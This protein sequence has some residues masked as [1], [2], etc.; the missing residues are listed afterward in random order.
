MKNVVS[1]IQVSYS[2]TLS[3]KI[4]VTSSR[5]ALD[6]LL[7]SWNQNTIELQEEFKILMLN[8][9]NEVLGIY[10]LSKGGVSGTVV[11]IKLLF[12]VALKCNASGLILCHN[13]PSGNTQP[14]SQDKDI[15]CKILK[16]AA[17]MELSI[18]DHMIITRHGHYSFAE[19]GLLR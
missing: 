12:A 7:S 17:L 14:S 9:A 3:E 2:T 8:R 1:E 13:H 19:N 15:T 18:I 4:K 11:D 6:V 5:E 10:P 16:V